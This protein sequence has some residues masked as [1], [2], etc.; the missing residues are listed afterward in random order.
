MNRKQV[1]FVIGVGVAILIVAMGSLW[2]K[3]KS[4][5]AEGLQTISEAE[6]FGKSAT[7]VQCIDAAIAR[8]EACDGDLCRMMATPFASNCL[9]ESRRTPELCRGVPSAGGTD[10]GVA[11]RR[12][13]CGEVI[14]GEASWEA[15]QGIFLVIQADCDDRD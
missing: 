9:H 8:F 15:C 7:D 5:M 14:G 3:V 4:V 10:Q 2:F 13:R 12:G 6:Q 1:V 11:W